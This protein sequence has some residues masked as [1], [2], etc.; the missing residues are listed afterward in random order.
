[1]SDVELEQPP[2]LVFS[3]ETAAELLSLSR[4]RMFAL[5]KSGSIKSVRIGRLRRIPAESLNDYVTQ[6]VN[7]QPETLRGS[8][9]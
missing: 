7:S 9:D 6:L 4:T 5:I 8:Q 1:M 3:V 2:P